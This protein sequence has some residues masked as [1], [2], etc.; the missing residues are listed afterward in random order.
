MSEERKVEVA[1]KAR[2]IDAPATKDVLNKAMDQLT[3]SEKAQLKTDE[4][5]QEKRARFARVLERGFINDRLNVELPPHLHGEW[6]LDDPVAIDRA[7]ALG[8][9]IDKEYA[10]KRGLHSSGDGA[11]KVGDVIFMVQSMEDHMLMEEIRQKRFEDMHGKPGKPSQKE[12]REYAASVKA[13]APEVPIID[14]SRAREA[15]KDELEAALKA[16]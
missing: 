1:G 15:R 10:T 4:T 2:L 9:D 3:E 16:K 8:F 7:R 6:V 12:E 14:E 13:K 5:T 11:A